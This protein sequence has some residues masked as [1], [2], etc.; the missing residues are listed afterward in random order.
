MT[1]PST[2]A[3]ASPPDRLGAPPRQAAP[4]GLWLR[5]FIRLAGRISAGELSVIF[6]N[7]SHRT[8]VGGDPGPRAILRINRRRALP[9]LALG[10]DIGFAEAYMD[11]DWESPDLTALLE[12]AL[13]NEQHAGG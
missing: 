2:S 3:P 5:G 11:G 7:G 10:G 9:R 13:V 4:G 6:A 12:L 1:A 8:F